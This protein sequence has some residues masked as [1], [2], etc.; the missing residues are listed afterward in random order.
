LS[1]W[2]YQAESAGW[3]NT[4]LAGAFELRNGLPKKIN[5]AKVGPDLIVAMSSE[6]IFDFLGVRLNSE[7]AIE[8]TITIN[9][10]FPDKDE[11]FLL[12]LKNAHL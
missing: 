1:K 9:I 5:A 6:L 10:V 11:K 8:K 12:E 2:A 3:R 4:Y 7:L